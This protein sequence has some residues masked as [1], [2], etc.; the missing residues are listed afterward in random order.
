MSFLSDYFIELLIDIIQEYVDPTWIQTINDNKLRE[1]LSLQKEREKL[2]LTNKLDKMDANQRY[3]YVQKQNIGAVN[4]FKNAEQSHQEYINSEEFK[5]NTLKERLEYLK[6]IYNQNSN[7]IDVMKIQGIDVD[8]NLPDIQ[9]AEEGYYNEQD[10]DGEGESEE[11]IDMNV[12]D[13]DI[14][15]T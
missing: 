2:D 11:Y 1:K 12:E 6:N 14:M 5:Q 9:Q 3:V 4:W 15:G 8:V 7:E 10:I 13:E